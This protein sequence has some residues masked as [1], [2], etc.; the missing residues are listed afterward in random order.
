MLAPMSSL[1]V[2]GMVIGDTRV[3]TRIA[4]RARAVLPENI[5]THMKLTIPMGTLYSIK[6]PVTMSVLPAK[7]TLDRRNARAGMATRDTPRMAN[8]GAGWRSTSPS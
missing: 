8:S 4:V 3:E 5:P 6:I 1:S 7:I 2:S